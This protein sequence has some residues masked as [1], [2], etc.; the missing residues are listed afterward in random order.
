MGAL[1]VLTLAGM[2]TAFL[3]RVLGGFPADGTAASIPASAP[4]EEVYGAESI[5]EATQLFSSKYMSVV[6]EIASFQTDPDLRRAEARRQEMVSFGG[7][8]A[9]ALKVFAVRM[10]SG[11]EELV[12]RPDA[13]LEPLPVQ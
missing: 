8:L 7:T 11:L 2:V 1:T 10:Q 4:I 3:I 6:D 12:V 5:E 13:Q 9:E